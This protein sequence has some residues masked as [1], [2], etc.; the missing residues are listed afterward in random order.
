MSKNATRTTSVHPSFPMKTEDSGSGN[1]ETFSPSTEPDFVEP[2]MEL[3][4]GW[5]N[6][7]SFANLKALRRTIHRY[8]EPGWTEFLSTARMAG[9]FEELGFHLIWG[10]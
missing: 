3:L 9:I 2:P 5:T 6:P 7:S 10:P 1:A 4:P 8:P